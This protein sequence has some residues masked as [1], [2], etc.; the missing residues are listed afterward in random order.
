MDIP[1][2]NLDLQQE[3]IL[4]NSKKTYYEDSGKISK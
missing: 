2:D 3:N 1:N 4:E